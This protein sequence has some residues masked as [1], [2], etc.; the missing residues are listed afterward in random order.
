MAQ[1]LQFKECDFDGRFNAH[2][3]M[4]SAALTRMLFYRDLSVRKF[5]PSRPR[6]RGDPV[7]LTICDIGTKQTFPTATKNRTAK[8][9]V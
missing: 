9:P 2:R 3:N 6:R 1:G 4:A 8:V 5:A 7:R